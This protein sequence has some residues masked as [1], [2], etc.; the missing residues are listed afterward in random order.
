MNWDII[1]GHRMQFKRP[2]QQEWG[3][4]PNDRLDV[5]AGRR[6]PL[7]GHPRKAYGIAQD[8]AEVQVKAFEEAHKDSDPGVTA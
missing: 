7:A 3:R 8:Q 4:L 1:E 2:V 6:D 5:I